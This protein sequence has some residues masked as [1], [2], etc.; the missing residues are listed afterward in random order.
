MKKT[1][2]VLGIIILIIIIF[3]FIKSCEPR[4]KPTEE[5]LIN[6]ENTYNLSEEEEMS[7]FILANTDFTCQI[8]KD[9][10][11]TENEE[12]TKTLLNEAY[13]KYGLPV[14]NDEIMIIILDKYENNESVINTIKENVKNCP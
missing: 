2:V 12:N 9:P 5:E 1:L 8:I 4:T 6:E 7:A 11:I 13:K 3:L 10:T 14:E